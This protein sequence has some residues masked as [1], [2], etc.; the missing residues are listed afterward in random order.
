MLKIKDIEDTG[1]KGLD[2]PGISYS[3]PEP[4]PPLSPLDIPP[5]LRSNAAGDLL[6]KA[7]QAEYDNQRASFPGNEGCRVRY[8]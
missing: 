2:L 6:E 1:T 5:P 8:F 7:V 4:Y 3:S